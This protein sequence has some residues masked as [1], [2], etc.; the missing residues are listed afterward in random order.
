[1]TNQAQPIPHDD[2]QALKKAWEIYIGEETEEEGR[3]KVLA[4]KKSW[5]LCDCGKSRMSYPHWP[6]TTYEEGMDQLR[7]LLGQSH[8]LYLAHCWVSRLRQQSAAEYTIALVQE[9]CPTVK[10]S[11]SDGGSRPKAPHQKANCE[12]TCKPVLRENTCHCLCRC[13][14][15]REECPVHRVV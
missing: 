5:K 12:T 2:F 9:N 11:H 10:S 7:C 15:H 4:H 1:M 6:P 13:G 8:R 14:R 3:A